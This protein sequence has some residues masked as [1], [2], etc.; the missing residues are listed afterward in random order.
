MKKVYV[1]SDGEY[2]KVGISQNIKKRISQLKTA[3][4]KELTLLYS[5]D[6]G[7]YIESKIH[8]DLSSYRS[9][10]GG[11]WFIHNKETIAIIESYID[12]DNIIKSEYI[13]E[14]CDICKSNMEIQNGPYG[15]YFRCFNY[16]KCKFAKNIK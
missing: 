4:P 6:G 9:R 11:E 12:N 5:L 7:R 2:I 14:K 8:K 13:N 10:E 3:S 16:P 1:I 15:K